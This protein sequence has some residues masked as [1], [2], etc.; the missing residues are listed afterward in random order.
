MPESIAGETY[1]LC[2]DIVRLKFAYYDYKKKEWHE[3]WSTRIPG[4]GF[5]P[6][7]VRIV[8]TVLDERGKEV[9][10]ATDARIN[11]TEFVGYR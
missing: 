7:H 8:L 9:S 2:P 6:S 10:Y 1:V 3:D 5:L 4:T 11:M